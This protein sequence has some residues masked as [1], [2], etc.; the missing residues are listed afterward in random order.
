MPVSSL[1]VVLMN[2]VGRWSSL[3]NF[4]LP[5]VSAC[6]SLPRVINM[7]LGCEAQL[8]TLNKE[9]GMGRQVFK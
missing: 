7:L 8:P 5:R 4:Y 9:Y 2:L 6:P 3:L 1:F